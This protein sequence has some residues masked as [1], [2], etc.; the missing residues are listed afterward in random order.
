M[1]ELRFF[2]TYRAA[3][4]RKTVERDYDAGT[5]GGVLTAIE[6]EWPELAGDILADGEIR[7]QLSVLVNGREV[8]HLAGTDTAVGDGDT[9][10]VFPP[11]AGG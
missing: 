10:S 7:P 11:V 8:T 6:E 1:V 4:G 5:V 3:V 9:V 2:A